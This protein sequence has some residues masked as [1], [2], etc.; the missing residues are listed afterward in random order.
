MSTVTAKRFTIEEYERLAKLGFFQENDRVELIKG[1]IISM[2]AKGTPHAVCE[3]RL[4]REL[5]KLIGERATLRSQLPII[6]P[7]SSEPEPDRVIA[8]NRDDDYLNSHPTPEDI[9][10]LIEISDSTLK[11]DQDVKLPL[12]AEAGI[13]YYWII[14][15]AD[16]HLEMYSDAIQDLQGKFTYRRKEILLPNETVIIPC[17]PDL[18]LDLSKVFPNTSSIKHQTNI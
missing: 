16:N 9:L 7:D 11:F 17:F 8:K 10:L 14:N 4:E 6:I 5:N 13:T 12:Y 18:T 1:E 2:A 3:T 15:L